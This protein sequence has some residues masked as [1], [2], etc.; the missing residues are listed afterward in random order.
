MAKYPT[1]MLVVALAL[2]GPDGRVLMH[3]RPAG[4]PHAGLWEFPGGKVENGETPRFALVREIAEETGIVIAEGALTP[5]GFAE[6]AGRD[7]GRGIV[8]LLYTCADWQGDPVPLEGGELAW[9]TPAEITMLDR[10][11]LDCALVAQL[12]GRQTGD[13]GKEG[14]QG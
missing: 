2:H 3:R 4:K 8:I 14:C 13:A 7:G 1:W 10:P 12:F 9:F 5:A 11:P 6:S